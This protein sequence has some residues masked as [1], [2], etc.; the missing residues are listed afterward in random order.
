MSLRLD[1]SKFENSQG[2]TVTLYIKQTKKKNKESKERRKKEKHE[3][4]RRKKEKKKKRVKAWPDVV[5]QIFTP[6]SVDGA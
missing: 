6:Y 2:Y 4:D 5:E 3:K 1:C